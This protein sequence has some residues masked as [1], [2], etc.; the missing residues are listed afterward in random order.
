M[1]GISIKP[2]SVPGTERIVRCAFDY[3]RGKRR[4]VTAVHK[5]NIMKHTDGLFLATRD[6]DRQGLSGH[7][8]RRAD[9]RQ[10]V[11]AADAEAGTVRRAGPAEPVRRHPQRSG[12]RTGRRLGRGARSEHRAERCGFRGHARQ[13]SQV[14]GA[15]QGQPDGGDLVRHVD[16][17]APGRGRGGRPLGSKPSRR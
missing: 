7:R 13:R 12:G 16:A 6:P 17:A 2:I 5:A 15:E 11:H 3:A 1:T 8:V 4:K 10:H 14:Q 9:R